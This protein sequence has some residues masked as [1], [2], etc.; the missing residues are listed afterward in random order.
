M[1]IKALPVDIFRC[2]LGDCTNN[3]VSARN[4]RLLV[5]CPDGHEA[6][7]SEHIPDNFCHVVSDELLGETYYFIRPAT[8]KDGKVVD[9]GNDWYMM[10]GNLAYTSDHRFFCLV[11]GLHYGIP[12]HDRVEF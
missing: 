4:R 11:G 10:G 12:I 6:I 1:I 2:P 9:R 7:D 3:G 8:V 5:A